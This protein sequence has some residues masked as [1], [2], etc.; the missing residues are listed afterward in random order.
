MGWPLAEREVPGKLNHSLHAQGTWQQQ[1]IVHWQTGSIAHKAYAICCQLGPHAGGRPLVSRPG[2][3]FSFFLDFPLPLPALS[4]YCQSSNGTGVLLVGGPNLERV[5]RMTLLVKLWST[6]HRL[7]VTELPV[8]TL[9]TKTLVQK[10]QICHKQ[11][12]TTNPKN[13]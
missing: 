7:P 8:T 12:P 11:G 2:I 6:S 10:R 9:K 3:T 4:S 1:V 13:S 5:F